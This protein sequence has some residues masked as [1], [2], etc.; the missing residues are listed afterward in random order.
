MD[1]HINHG[2]AGLCPPADSTTASSGEP[3]T[4]TSTMGFVLLSAGEQRVLS[5]LITTAEGSGGLIHSMS[6]MFLSTLLG[7]NPFP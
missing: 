2:G 1:C 6:I 4:P 5:G 7:W 3:V